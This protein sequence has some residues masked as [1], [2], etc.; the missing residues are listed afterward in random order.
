MS[1]QSDFEQCYEYAEEFEE[2]RDRLTQAQNNIVFMQNESERYKKKLRICTMLCVLSAVVTL[3][4]VL[5][6]IFLHNTSS[7]GLLPFLVISVIVFVISFVNAVKTKKEFRDFEC[8]KPSMIQKYSAEA[9]ESMRAMESLLA[10]IYEENLFSIVPANYFYTEAIEFCLTRIYNKMANTATNA[11]L[12]L[13]A[14]I[15]RLEQMECWER[16]HNEHMDGLDN[17]KRA[18][19]LNTLITMVESNKSNK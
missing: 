1:L 17:I 5:I 6:I 14:E 8:Q 10:E 15:K 13:D 9:D 3:F 11:L 7:I 4:A 19:D 12:Q 16:M 18:I 2:Q